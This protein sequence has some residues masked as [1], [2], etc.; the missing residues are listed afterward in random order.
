[1]SGPNRPDQGTGGKSSNDRDD[2]EE[3]TDTGFQRAYSALNPSSTRSPLTSLRIWRST[4]TTATKPPNPPR[5]C[6]HRD[7]PGWLE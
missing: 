6:R 7:G 4:T 5:T 1:M 2:G 3:L